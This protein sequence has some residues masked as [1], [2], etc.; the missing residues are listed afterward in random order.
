MDSFSHIYFSQMLLRYRL[1]KNLT[2]E[3]L[4]DI[5]HCSDRCI[6]KW[7]AGESIPRADKLFRIAKALGVS[8]DTL[9]G[10]E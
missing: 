2:Q 5:L 3:D 10:L 8:S 6:Q 1:L 9:L 7:E 4:A